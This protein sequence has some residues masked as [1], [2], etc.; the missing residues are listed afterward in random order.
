MPR[1]YSRHQRLAAELMRN[2]SD[3]LRFDIKDPGVAGVSL[4]KV[5]LSR[6]LSVAQ[7]YFSLLQPDGDPKPALDGLGRAAGF[8]RSKLGQ[9]MK[10]R[11]VPELRFTH[12]DSI[13]HADRISR[14]I[15]AANRPNGEG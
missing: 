8:L 12:D 11:H 15:D 1:E 13:A 3:V 9:S 2:L 7:V 4:T 6:D 10:I 14:L 5:D